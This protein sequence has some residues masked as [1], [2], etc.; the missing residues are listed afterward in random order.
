LPLTGGNINGSLAVE[1][2]GW[3]ADGLKVGGVN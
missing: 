3:F 2:A 1:D